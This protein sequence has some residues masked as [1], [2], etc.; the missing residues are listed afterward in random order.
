[1]STLTVQS[2]LETTTVSKIKDLPVLLKGLYVYGVITPIK[3]NM[4]PTELLHQLSIY[5]PDILSLTIKDLITHEK[6][7]D[8]F[9][10]T[11]KVVVMW[12]M[13]VLM[14]GAYS[15]T[16]VYISIKQMTPIPWEDMVLPLIG[17]ILLVLHERGVVS[18]ENRDILSTLTGGHPALTFLESITQRIANPERKMNSKVKKVDNPKVDTDN[19]Y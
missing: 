18:K 14:A 13:L 5:D 1:M 3:P 4:S 7:K 17:P 12:V 15:F 11:A 19:D 9:C 6:Q 2:L 16:N 8:S 10:N